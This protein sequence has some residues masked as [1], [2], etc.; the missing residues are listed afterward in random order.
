MEST[1]SDSEPGDESIP[2]P[3]TESTFGASLPLRALL[4]GDGPAM[5]K[6]EQRMSAG[7]DQ[8]RYIVDHVETLADAFGAILNSEY[9]VYVVDHYVGP[10][11]GFDLLARI[12][13]EDLRVPVVF[14]AGSSDH[15][16]GVTAVAAGAA[17][18]IVED[19]I[20][21]D[22]L[23]QSLIQAVAQRTTL[24]QLTA[25]GVAIDGAAPT[26]AQIL[27][28][29]AER[30]R[31]PAAE[32]LDYAR[33]SLMY[34][35][36]AH[37]V[38]ALASIEDQANGLLTLANDLVDLSMLEGGHLEFASA[39]FSLRG[40]IANVKRLLETTTKGRSIEIV[41]HVADDVPDV[42]TGDPGRL[43][44][45]IARF[46]ESVMERTASDRILLEIGIEERNT[47]TVTL[48]IAITAADHI[49]V[50][51]TSN[52][53]SPAE[54]HITLGMPVVL[55]T[56]SRMGG[57]I[58]LGGNSSRSDGIQFTIRLE[59]GTEKEE[60]PQPVANRPATERPILVIADSVADRREMLK[61]LSEADLP[62]VVAATVDDWME[63]RESSIDNPVMPAL[64]VIDS[65]NDSFAEA[66]RFIQ[67]APELI[68]IVVVAA[69][70][71]RGDAARCRHHGI[72]GY[73][74]KPMGDNDLVDV[75]GSTLSLAASGDT[76]TLVTRHWLRDGRPS[77]RVLVVDDSQTNR[78]LM[79]R[80]LEE[81]GHSTTTAT[82]GLEAIEMVE[83]ATF[84]V[85]L[86]DVM[87]PGMDGLEATRII[88][89]RRQPANR[90]VIVGVSAFTDDLSKNR[91]R[92]AGMTTF[93]AK[94]IRPDDLFAAVEQQSP[95]PSESEDEPEPEAA[96]AGS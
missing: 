8:G 58:A 40:L 67:R 82:D 11:T 89:E 41:D 59:I 36:P 13:E 70:G 17:C 22:L 24:S 88:C 16:T 80:M 78:F 57:R 69:S 21:S 23:E 31:N 64:V 75:V 38:E 27:S 63:M 83:R 50:G 77:L 15:G 51:P 39:Q 93:L 19:R 9:D 56:L 55:E 12:T 32:I 90:P 91:G 1:T 52:D 26:K 49:P 47:T 45:I 25:A 44:R 29:I 94:P 73:L 14:V 66:D 35:L 10:R 68:P 79:T 3:S 34:A 76:T 86:M 72:N 96:A 48:H 18:Y 54:E 46:G 42:I 7:I 62:H 2:E 28:H 81:R 95:A 71:R 53:P 61:A 37:T 4:V 60:I 6:I 43:R 33:D 5:P 74:A 85:V 65:N 92:E 30:L 84:D 87:M 20:D